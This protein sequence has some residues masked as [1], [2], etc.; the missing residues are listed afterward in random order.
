MGHQQVSYVMAPKEFLEQILF[1]DAEIQPRAWIIRAAVTKIDYEI[2][3][4]SIFSDILTSLDI[5]P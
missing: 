4:T 5:M 3:R 2:Q 1:V